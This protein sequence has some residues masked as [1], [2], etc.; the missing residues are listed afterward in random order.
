[1]RP[2]NTIDPIAVAAQLVTLIYQAVPRQT[3]A[4]DPVVVT[5]GV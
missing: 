3:D 5:I 4:R 2:H 1:L